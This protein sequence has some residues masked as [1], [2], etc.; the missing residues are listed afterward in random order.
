MNTNQAQDAF[1]STQIRKNHD[2]APVDNVDTVVIGA[3]Q[4]G[5]STAYHLTRRNQSVLVLEAL[6]RVGD[7][8]RRRYDSLR[9]YSPSQYDGLPGWDMPMP[10]WSFPTKDELADYLEQYAEKFQLPVRTGVTVERIE[11]AEG[12]YVVQTATGP[13]AADNVVVATGTWQVPKLPSFAGQLDPSI[14]QLHS[15]AYRNL[16]QLQPGPALVVGAAHSGADLALELSESHETTMAGPIRGELPFDFAGAAAHAALPLLWFAANRILTV[17]TPMGRKAREH[18]LHEGGPLLRVKR[19]HLAAAGVAITEQKVTGVADG[20]PMLADGQP[21]DVRNVV[22]C[23]GFRHDM[24][25]VEVPLTI[26]ESTGLPVHDRGL[27]DQPGLYFVGLPF[28]SRFASTLVGG[29]G[30]DADRIA[31]HIAGRPALAN[32]IAPVDEREPAAG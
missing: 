22:W 13:I 14:T 16:S 28:L 30:A 4:A 8:W 12:G 24:S 1:R 6:P 11:R 7:V 5:L 17:R 25:W 15:S 18:V 31:A 29:V 19:E 10:R 27:T 26:D 20:R 9:L 23:T 2:L 32:R 21:L 3:G